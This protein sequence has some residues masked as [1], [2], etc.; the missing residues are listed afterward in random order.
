MEA[1]ATGIPVIA[2]AVGGMAEL[3]S[4]GHTGFLCAAGSIDQ[5]VEKVT[6]LFENRSLSR[7]MGENARRYA[8]SHFDIQTTIASFE[9]TFSALLENVEAT[10]SRLVKPAA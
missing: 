2:S 5:F 9:K 8:E 10:D 3:V 6:L 7:Q 1:L 4:H